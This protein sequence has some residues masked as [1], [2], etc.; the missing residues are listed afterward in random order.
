MTSTIQKKTLKTV[1]LTILTVLVVLIGCGLSNVT[2]A[3]THVE[4]GDK[5]INRTKNLGAGLHF[6]NWRNPHL[7]SYPQFEYQ[8]RHNKTG[9]TVFG[10]CFESGKSWRQG[11]VYVAKRPSSYARY[12]NFGE[13]TKKLL[14]LALYYGYNTGK[15]ALGNGK[16]RYGN[17]N[18]YWAAT[19]VLVWEIT[20][21]DLKLSDGKLKH[22][23]NQ[24]DNLIAKSTEAK[25]CYEWIKE[26]ILEH[27]DGPSFAASTKA[28]AKTYTMRYDYKKN[29]WS[30]TLT[31]STK[32]NTY[33]KTS[34]SSDSLS[35]SRDGYKYTFSTKS[36]GTKTAV[37]M[38]KD[39]NGTSQP[40]MIYKPN[41]GDL[42]ALIFGSTDPTRFYA[43]FKTETMSTTTIVKK[44][45]DGSS[46]AGFSFKITNEDNGYS[47]VHKTD[48][49]GKI[50][51]KAYPGTY[52]ATEQLTSSQKAKGFTPITFTF[53]VQDGKTLTKEVTNPVSTIPV[54]IVKESQNKAAGFLFEIK[55]SSGKTVYEGVTKQDPA[56]EK[57]GLIQTKLYPGT[58]TVTEKL[59]EEQ[60]KAGYS[61]RETSKKI[62][63]TASDTSVKV[64]FFNYY[65]EPKENELTIRKATTDG[66]PT[67][68]FRFDITGTIAATGKAFSVTDCVTDSRGRFTMEIEPGTYTITEKMTEKQKLRYETPKAQ[69]VTIK[70]G[71]SA[72]VSF[73]NEAKSSPVE[74]IKKSSDGNIANIE[75]VITGTYAWGDAMEETVRTT[76]QDGKLHIDLPPGTYTFTENLPEEGMYAPVRPQ[77]ITLTGSETETT[78]LTFVNKPFTMKLTKYEIL[79]DGTKTT[80]P[81]SGA[82]YEVSYKGEE[83][84]EF[85]GSYT[86]GPDGSFTVEGVKAGIYTLVEMVTPNGY[87]GKEEPLTVSVKAG[88]AETEVVDYN[89]RQYGSLA[90]DKVDNEGYAVEGAEFTLYGVQYWT[91]SA[92]YEE[93][94]VWCYVD[95]SGGIDL[96]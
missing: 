41:N 56:N 14:N 45:Q 21:G 58:Y 43:K 89:Q 79:E 54:K 16:D 68:G 94:N 60:I 7:P 23:A 4:A 96:Q 20:D 13:N 18:D 25:N 62:K 91:R 67:E 74:V 59:T 76:D 12:K 3:S 49:K 36:A 95:P 40:L 15:G 61:A 11:N 81:V 29:R 6:S 51:F 30:V 9:D 63:V 75:F 50:V 28:K 83:G 5:G 87:I 19:Q 31:D 64:D 52:K 34:E 57:Q 2:F 26:Q 38:N 55:D 90:I 39:A 10:Y 27:L 72:V 71:D 22:S 42:Q 44:N 88:D 70:E 69:E 8:V 47:K 73:T 32:V 92:G 78:S 24:N 84:E 46:P 48:S 86:T 82:V 77:T 17:Q 80:D 93:G 65:H 66:G 35:M 85:I 33:T 1:I 53:K 37:L